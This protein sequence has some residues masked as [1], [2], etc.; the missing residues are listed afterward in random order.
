[1]VDRFP[2]GLAFQLQNAGVKLDVAP[3]GD[4]LPERMIKT[5]EEITALRNGNKASAAAFRAITKTLEESTI[6]NGFIIHQGRKLTSERLREIIAM[7]CF[8]QGAIASDTI[9]AGGDQACNC[10]EAGHGPLRANEL[11]VCDVFPRRLADGYWGDMTRTFLKGTASDASSAPS[12]VATNSP[13]KQS[14]RASPAD[15]CKKSSTISS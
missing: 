8:E 2:A 7:A 10:H 13:S 5:P 11:I 4:C 6:R 15:Q 9:A 3:P 14:N 12:N 1:M